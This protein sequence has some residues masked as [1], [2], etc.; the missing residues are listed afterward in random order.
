[1]TKLEIKL[2]KDLYE[3]VN[4]LFAFTFYSRYK[5]EPEDIVLFITKYQE[6]GIILYENDKLSLTDEGKN[7]VLKKSFTVHNQG[8]FSNIPKEYL[9]NKLE[10]NT[11][12]LPNIS[13][14]SA[15]IINLK[16]VE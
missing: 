13:D 10:I 8:R 16:G 4:G 2:L 11:P 1:M 12:Y 5:I 9:A 14:I 7:L 3:S 15:E 6:Q